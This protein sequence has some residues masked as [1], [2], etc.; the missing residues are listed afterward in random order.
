MPTMAMGPVE[1]EIT[2][3]LTC[4]KAAPENRAPIT[5]DATRRLNF[6]MFN[7]QSKN[8]TACIEIS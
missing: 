2:P 3:T 1:D 7:L 6:M 4:A 5:T 8:G